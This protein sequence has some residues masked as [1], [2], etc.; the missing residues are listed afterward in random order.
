M[1]GSVSA[2]PSRRADV[3]SGI[4]PAV[5]MPPT[6]VPANSLRPP[7]ERAGAS[8]E[9][10]TRRLRAWAPAGKAAALF[11]L[12]APLIVAL[13]ANLVGGSVVRA[14]L[15]AGALAAIWTAGVLAL[16]ALA[17]E[18]RYLLGERLDPPA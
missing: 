10:T 18:A 2:R 5:R 3:R 14:A 1:P 17:A 12:P 13:V 15:T 8:A 6:A 9:R 11:L 7:G 16:R 4:R